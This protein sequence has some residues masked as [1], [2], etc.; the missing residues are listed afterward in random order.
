MDELRMATYS[1]KPLASKDFV[2][3]LEG[4]IGTD[5]QVRGRGRPRKNSTHGSA[6][7]AAATS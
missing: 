4:A 5:L 3:K 7:R 6:L 2:Q 1:G